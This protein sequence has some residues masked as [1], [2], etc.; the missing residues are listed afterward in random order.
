MVTLSEGRRGLGEPCVDGFVM[1]SLLLR[2]MSGWSRIFPNED[3]FLCFFS[4]RG[5]LE[6]SWLPDELVKV[7][8]AKRPDFLLP[9]EP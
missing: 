9:Q 6:A 3:L 2:G 1:L 5:E 8:S 4:V 7:D